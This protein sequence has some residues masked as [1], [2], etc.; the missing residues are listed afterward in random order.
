MKPRKT[1]YLKKVLSKKKFQ[2]YPKKSNHHQFY[3]LVVDGV[4]Q[5]VY[6]YF[7]HGKKEYDS[8]LMGEIKK[9]LKF[10]SSSDAED[11]FDCPMSGDDYVDML[12]SIGVLPP[13]DDDDSD[14]GKK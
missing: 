9:Q 11:Y 6:T 4:K 14:S 10:N 8:R 12:R 2:F 13:D 5:R 3:Y 1:K 7:S